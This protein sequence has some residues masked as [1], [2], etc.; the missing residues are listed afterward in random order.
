MS[1]NVSTH[2]LSSHSEQQCLR[3]HVRGNKEI[4]K[5]TTMPRKRSKDSSATY[6]NRFPVSVSLESTAYLSE[7]ESEQVF[8]DLVSIHFLQASQDLFIQHQTHRQN[9]RSPVNINMNTLNPYGHFNI[10]YYIEIYRDM[11]GVTCC[12]VVSF[13]HE[14][15]AWYTCK[16]VRME[17]TM[18]TK[19][20]AFE[21]DIDCI[22]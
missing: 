19:G 15:V 1:Q 22:L 17:E 5:T 2:Q 14:E 16:R 21:F 9:A 20:K 4:I 7:S 3:H 8:L 13:C 12:S 18:Y 11:I 10:I 6:A